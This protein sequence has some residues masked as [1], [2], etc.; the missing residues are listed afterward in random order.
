[1]GW[2]RPGT[3]FLN[4]TIEGRVRGLQ[5]S[6]YQVAREGDCRGCIECSKYN[7]WMSF[8]FAHKD[9]KYWHFIVQTAEAAGFEYAGCVVQSNGAHSFKKRQHPFSVLSGQLIINF[10]KIKNP[11]RVEKLVHGTSVYSLIIETIESVI[12]SKGGAKLEQINDELII[13]GLEFGFLDILSKEYRDLT[14]LLFDNFDY[15]ET[16]QQFHIKRE[17]KFKAQLPLEVRIKYFLIS[18]LKRSE[19]EKRSPTTDEIIL[20]I[21]PL[22]KNGI[23][24]E[25]QTI[26]TELEKI[27]EKVDVDQWRLR[28]DGNLE[29]DLR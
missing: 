10:K 21:M 20:H 12:A 5:S 3:D 13:K 4:G 25:N 22:L 2:K 7:R 27:A 9:P 15:D 11:K 19:A 16:S 8:V 14:P 17:R 6:D 26:L 1:M 18:Y 29:L 24:P 28:S 23:T